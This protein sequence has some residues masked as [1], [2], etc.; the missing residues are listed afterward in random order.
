ML[1]DPEAVTAVISDL[2]GGSSGT[3][4]V[5]DPMDT[6]EE[7]KVVQS[8]VRN[9]SFIGERSNIECCLCATTFHD[10]ASCEFHMKECHTADITENYQ[11]RNKLKTLR[12]SCPI[13]QQG[14][15]R[16]MSI[17]KHLSDKTFTEKPA[18][19]TSDAKKWRK[20]TQ[21]QACGKIFS[22]KFE[23]MYHYDRVHETNKT[24][25]CDRC[26]K[27]FATH[28]LLN[29]HMVTH[30]PKRHICSICGKLFPQIYQLTSHMDT[31]L[32]VKKYKCDLCPKTFS[33]KRVLESH[34]LQHSAVEAKP[35]RCN[36]CPKMYKWREDL[37]AHR[38]AV[39]EGI[40][41]YHCSYCNKGYTS[42]SNKKYHEKRCSLNPDQMG[43]DETSKT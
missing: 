3:D 37:T 33:H 34:V 5:V 25:K 6:M 29:R 12:F 24:I 18:Q 21:C 31:H 1:D 7:E 2:E 40:Y 42:S 32:T 17:E 41:A 43:K 13:C 38:K 35:F 14:F 28:K 30:G 23:A 19:K 9:Y 15:R 39:H 4:S 20:P 22:D 16:K 27:F 11:Y 8:P 36:E 26:E 10:I